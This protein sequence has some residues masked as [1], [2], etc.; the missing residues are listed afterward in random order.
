MSARTHRRS[1]PSSASTARIPFSRWPSRS[2]R[3]CGD[4][5]ESR[6][7][8][9]CRRRR[10]ACR[11]GQGSKSE[12]RCRLPTTATPRSGVRRR[13][14]WSHSRRVAAT[15][16]GATTAIS[17]RSSRGARLT[18]AG[19][20]NWWWTTSASWRR[21]GIRRYRLI[22]ES[23]PPA[24][25]AISPSCCARVA[26]ISGGARSSWSTGGST[27]SSAAHGRVGCDLPRRRPRV[28]GDSGLEAGAQVGRP[29][30]EHPFIR[31]AR[32]AGIELAV[33]LIPDLPS[34]TYDEAIQGASA[35]SKSW[36]IASMTS[37]CCGSRPPARRG[38]VAIRSAS[39]SYSSN[40][41]VRRGQ[42]QLS[43]NAL[44]VNDPAMTP[45][46]WTEA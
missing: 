10:R 5:H 24:F 25:A 28:D 35:T 8:E 36:P 27:P 46:E 26:S 31:D 39:G 6:H 2:R 45:D 11:S 41:R 34:T 37:T 13:R 21:T 23:I 9:P 4:R 12:R 18:E 38:W 14:G 20:P 1:T 17:S 42:A 43:I 19:T 29:R 40:C 44:P 7:V 15:G 33:N 3:A 32:A 22:T 16:G 30:R